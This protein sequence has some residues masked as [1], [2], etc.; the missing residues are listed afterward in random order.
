MHETKPTETKGRCDFYVRDQVEVRIG[1][2]GVG[3]ISWSIAEHRFVLRLYQISFE[4]NAEDL[5]TI[6]DYIDGLKGPS[7]PALP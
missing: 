4:L 2:T 5:R 1:S 3:S 6:A 7:L